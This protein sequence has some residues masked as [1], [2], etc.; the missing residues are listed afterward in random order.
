M[1][2]IP[3]PALTPTMEIL[4]FLFLPLL[5]IANFSL[6]RAKGSTQETPQILQGLKR[7]CLQRNTEDADLKS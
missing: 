3:N 4:F 2:K 6:I 1:Y 5:H 7:I